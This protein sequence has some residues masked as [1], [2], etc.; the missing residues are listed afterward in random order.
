MRPF[1]D[2]FLTFFREWL[3]SRAETL[4]VKLVEVAASISTIRLRV[5]GMTEGLVVHVTEREEI[6]VTVEIGGVEWD[7]LAEWVAPGVEAE[8]GVACI[9]CSPDERTVYPDYYALWTTLAY[10]PFAR[11]LATDLAPAT[12]IGLGG[13]AG[14]ST[15]AV[16]LRDDD[17]RGYERRIP[18]DL[19]HQ[20]HVDG[21][22][23][24]SNSSE[25]S[26]STISNG[27]ANSTS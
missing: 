15:W 23:D 16:L 10:E 6:A 2:H 8:G 3:D 22:P 14:E 27:S 7:T 4:P 25:V 11:W 26:V 17:H 12:A 18:L 20:D 5:S 13:A 19:Q 21:A 1:E 9:L 24:H